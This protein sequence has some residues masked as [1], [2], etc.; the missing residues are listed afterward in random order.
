MCKG[1][2]ACFRDAGTRCA[3]PLRG[4]RR[5]GGSSRWAK[6][7]WRASSMRHARSSG[8]GRPEQ[9]V[10]RRRSSTGQRR[11][12]RGGG[13][14]RTLRTRRRGTPDPGAAVASLASPDST[15]IEWSQHRGDLTSRWL[16]NRV[17]L[18]PSAPGGPMPR[19]PSRC[20]VHAA[21]TARSHSTPW[22]APARTA[23][24]HGPS[25][26]W[27][28]VGTPCSPAR[29]RRC[30]SAVPGAV[31]A[32]A[33]VPWG[34]TARAFFSPALPTGPTC[35]FASAR[36]DQVRAWLRRSRHTRP[37]VPRTAGRCPGAARR[38]RGRAA[39]APGAPRA[40]APCPRSSPGRAPRRSGG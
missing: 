11:R 32:C 1:S 34:R 17:P 27:Q 36:Q 28:Q 5:W 8:K 22:S 20:G 25:R 7:A 26:T 30:W 19:R 35:P 33:R 39:A 29:S 40:T 9:G 16:S 23:R 31:E 18:Q 6:P 3:R 21:R 10:R 24:G 4:S 14:G 13:N 12:L 38:W 15:T 37:G 2:G